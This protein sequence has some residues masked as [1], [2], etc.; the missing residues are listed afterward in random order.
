MQLSDYN[1]ASVKCEKSASSLIPPNIAGFI[2]V[3]EFSSVVT[4]GMKN[5]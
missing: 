1:F 5:G 4:Q 2:P 3:F